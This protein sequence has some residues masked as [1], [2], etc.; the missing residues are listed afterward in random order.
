MNKI[1]SLQFHPKNGTKKYDDL[2]SEI[3][4]GKI[5]IPKFQREFVWSKT[6]TAK[7][8]DSIL[9]GFPI[10]TFILWKT[11]DELRHYKDIGNATLPKT[12]KGDSAYYILD[13]QQRITS[14]YAVKKGLI[15]TKDGKEIDYKDIFINLSASIEDEDLVTVEK[16]EGGEFISVHDLLNQGIKYFVSN[17]PEELIDSIDDYKKKLTTYDFSTIEILDYLRISHQIGR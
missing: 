14:L 12:P 10:G 2:F 13:G 11:R 16:V 8:I 3:D 5:K 6:E 15:I 4:T 17:F 1:H 7:L 9:R